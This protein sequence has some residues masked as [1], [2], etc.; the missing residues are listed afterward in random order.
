MFGSLRSRLVFGIGAVQLVTWL[1]ILGVGGV[2]MWNEL[3]EGY[4]VE[5][6]Q[7]STA[8]TGVVDALDESQKTE[9]N[10][11]LI[12]KLPPALTEED[13]PEGITAADLRDHLVQVSHNGHI[14]FRSPSAPDEALDVPMGIND[15][16][17][18]GNSWKTLGR[19]DP[20]NGNHVV[21]AIRRFEVN[22]TIIATL[23]S[24]FL[25]LAGAALVGLML[26]SFLVTRLLKP[27]E[28]WA[29]HIGDMSPYDTD[30]IDDSEALKEVRPVL[31]ALNR[32]M[33]RVR[34]SIVFERRFV[35][36][37]AHELRTPLTAIRAQIEGGDWR[38]LST[39]QEMRMHK[40][41][42]GL[43]RA[44][45]LVNQLMDLA[46]SEEPRTST[47]DAPVDVAGLIGAKLM[48]I[49]NSSAIADPTRIA[50][51]A[52]EEPVWLRCSAHDIEVLVGNLVDNAV[53]YAGDKATIDVTLKPA[54]DRL[55][56]TVEDD[57]P[58][59]PE[60]KREEVFNRFV[61]LSPSTSYGSGLGL[62]LVKEIVTKFGGEV[63]LDRSEHLGGLRVTVTLPFET[64]QDAGADETQSASKEKLRVAG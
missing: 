22:T 46:R 28:G 36:D 32:M 3:E 25:P 45:R 13:L 63:F 15:L 52:P 49:I 9:L 24:V 41:Q 30:P 44:S 5:L 57:G 53:K 21:V 56:L 51:N 38:G 54:A 58:G 42:F 16:T 55:T 23:V 8:V 29:R 37:A 64:M 40:V 17:F 62:A 20:T 12:A 59:I 43:R 1:V 61:R 50:L 26:T 60:D 33:N 2:H 47:R 14:V 6:I 19:I 11:E 4:N 39:E 35:R 7:F 31:S 27:L 18:A 10:H 34:E 48:E